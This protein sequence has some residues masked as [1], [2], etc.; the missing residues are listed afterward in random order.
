MLTFIKIQ[1]N[2][3]QVIEP[4]RASVS[5]GVEQGRSPGG[6]CESKFPRPE[7]DRVPALPGAG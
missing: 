7:V 3:G 2:L 6:R 4:P 5:V 1:S